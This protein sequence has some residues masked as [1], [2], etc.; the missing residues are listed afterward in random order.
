MPKKQQDKLGGKEVEVVHNLPQSI[1]TER[2]V[3]G[4]MFTSDLS[5]QEAVAAGLKAEDFHLDSNRRIFRAIQKLV[6]DRKAI[7]LILVMEELEKSKEL[8]VV[9]GVPYL[10]GLLDGIVGNPNVKYYVDILK[11]KT[12]RRQVMHLANRA[13]GSAMDPSDPVKWTVSGLQEDLLRI[14]GDIT[15]EGVFIKE[16]SAEVLATLEEQMYSTREV[17]GLSFGIPEL[18]E[19]TTG[20]RD[21]EFIPLG[22][23]PGCVAPE[24]KIDGIPIAERQNQELSTLFGRALPSSP[25]LKGRSDLYEVLTLSGSRVV[26]T[27]GHRFLTP[28]GW[29]QLGNLRV[30]SLI[31]ADGSERG[32]SAKETTKG[33]QGC[34]SS[35][36]RPCGG[37]LP[38]AVV[39]YRDKL[40]K[41]R[42]TACEYN[43]SPDLSQYPSRSDFSFQLAPSAW[44][45]ALYPSPA[46]ASVSGWQDAWS[47]SDVR[48]LLPL[49]HMS[50]LQAR[51]VRSLPSEDRTFACDCHLG[52]SRFHGGSINLLRDQDV[53]GNVGPCAPRC[54]VL[55]RVPRQLARHESDLE[56]VRQAF[57][58]QIVSVKFV[59]HGEYYDISVPAHEHYSA[60]GLWHHNSGKTAFAVDVMRKNTKAGVPVAFFSIEMRKEEILHRILCQ[61]SDISYSAL[62]NPKNLSKQEFKELQLKW[63]GV[64]NEYPLKI[65]DEVRDIND[66]IPRAHLYI[67]RYGVKLIVID[68]LQIVTAPGEKE[69]ERV[70]YAADALTALAK[71]T[72]VPVLCLSQLTRPEDKKHAANVI[73]TIAM[74]RSSGKIEQNA[75]LVLFTHHPEDDNG[76]PTGEDLIVIGKQRSGVRGRVKCYFDGRTQRWEDRGP[77]KETPKQEKI[78]NK[79]GS[80]TTESEEN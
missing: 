54:E 12:M 78:F 73:P 50:R 4:A 37:L 3:L 57:W 26:V 64:V 66:I 38:P 35:G 67:R 25:F 46:N 20:M 19:I 15:K 58:D 6:N 56:D 16:F 75:H 23:F 59:R 62:R 27:V 71:S 76:D 34:Y 45:K 43:S 49:L 18:D 80:T 29:R 21:G 61:E 44:G 48:S 31:A 8:Q 36:P 47:S 65:D 79:A 69:Y 41:F 40:R 32:F 11:E 13:V 70:S 5:Y 53:R 72:K 51:A 52:T 30:G 77:K 14:Q 1:E 63:M 2:T 55:D 74:L 42:K 9:G 17:I 22:G 10:S 24:T 7:D 68:F 60:E 28:E 39:A 33:F